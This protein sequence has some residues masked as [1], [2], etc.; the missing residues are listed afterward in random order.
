[1]LLCFL[2]FSLKDIAY[3][4]LFPILFQIQSILNPPKRQSEFTKWF[5]QQQ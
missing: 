2:S 3:S 5:E 4:K 1:M